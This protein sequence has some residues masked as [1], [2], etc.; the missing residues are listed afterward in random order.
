V[1]TGPFGTQDLAGADHVAAGAA[2]LAP[3]LLAG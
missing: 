1:T 3:L 2:E